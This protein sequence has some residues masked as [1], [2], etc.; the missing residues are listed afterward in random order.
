M[1]G[2]ATLSIHIIDENDNAPFLNESTIDICQ[3]NGSTWANITAKDL[4][5]HPYGG[6]F[7]FRLLGDVEGKWKVDPAQGEL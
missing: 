4:D 5:E 3:S 6:P 7:N 1:T 2:T